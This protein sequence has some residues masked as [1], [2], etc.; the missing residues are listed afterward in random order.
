M[1]L[2]VVSYKMGVGVARDNNRYFKKLI[3]R[4]SIKRW[5]KT[6]YVDILLLRDSFVLALGIQQ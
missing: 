1:F 4:K 5:Q 6:I 2:Y 3:G